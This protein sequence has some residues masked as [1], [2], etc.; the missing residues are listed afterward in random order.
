MPTLQ[1]AHLGLDEHQVK[2]LTLI[3]RGLT[4]TQTAAN[5]NHSVQTVTY[6]VRRLVA[7]LGVGGDRAELVHT[8]YRL[9]IITPRP[10]I[11]TAPPM[12]PRCREVLRLVAAG[13]SYSQIAQH[14]HISDDTMRRHLETLRRALGARSRVELVSAAWSH[15]LLGPEA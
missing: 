13:Q 10:P 11:C 5:L 9:G 12:T 3:A 2:V 14:F 15:K 7:R 8:A 4:L 1:P 6:T